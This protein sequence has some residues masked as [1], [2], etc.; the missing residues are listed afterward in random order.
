M[1]C[2]LPCIVSENTG[3]IVRDGAD[4][5]VIPIRDAKR[6]EEAV[7]RLWQNRDEA[8]RMGNSAMDHVREFTWGAYAEGVIGVYRD[9]LGSRVA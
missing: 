8:A 7:L 1:A 5:I 3:S 2:G 6:I 4:G 9:L